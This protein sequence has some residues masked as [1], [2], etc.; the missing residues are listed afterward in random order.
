MI[1]QWRKTV[2]ND[3]TFAVRC[4]QDLTH[5]IGFKPVDEAYGVLGRMMRYCDL[6]D[7]PFL[8]LETPTSYVIN[9]EEAKNAR[10]MFSS[11]SFRGVNLVWEMR[12]PVTKKALDLMQD[13]NM[14]ECVDLS[15][16]TPSVES[17]ILYLAVHG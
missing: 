2:P 13:F 12:A 1:E 8:V 3:F 7:S 5:K 11:F 4:H 9:H 6:L 17:N 15:I 16:K 14:I 10:D